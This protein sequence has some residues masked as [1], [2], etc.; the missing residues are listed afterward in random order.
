MNLKLLFKKENNLN[1]D[2]ELKQ[3][4]KNLVVN[5]YH[6]EHNHSNNK[7]LGKQECIY[8]DTVEFFN[9]EFRKFENWYIENV[10]NIKETT[11]IEIAKKIIKKYHKLIDIY[12]VNLK[13]SKSDLDLS[14]SYAIAIGSFMGIL[15][16]IRY[17]GTWR[18]IGE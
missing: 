17:S 6:Y 3:R 11:L 10:T 7:T 15:D 2:D 5:C 4:I 16:N 13:Y 1:K 8:S 14:A 12:N 18:I 9:S